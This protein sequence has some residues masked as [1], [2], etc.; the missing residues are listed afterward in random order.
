MD[1]PPAFCYS[2]PVPESIRGPRNFSGP[3][4]LGTIKFR[5]VDLKT[6]NIAHVLGRQP[7]KCYPGIAQPPMT[8]AKETGA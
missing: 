6:K 7:S 4:F 3:S 2:Y 1:F 5:E 8:R